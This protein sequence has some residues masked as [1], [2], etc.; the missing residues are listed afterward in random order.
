M[1]TFV[2]SRAGQS[3]YVEVYHSF[4][5]A[6]RWEFD[7]GKNW[8]TFRYHPGMFKVQV[9]RQVF[10]GGGTQE[11]SMEQLLGSLVQEIESRSTANPKLNPEKVGSTPSGGE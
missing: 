4:L 5:N 8:K 11:G 10:A 3:D 9:Q 2:K 6:G 1:Q 7:M